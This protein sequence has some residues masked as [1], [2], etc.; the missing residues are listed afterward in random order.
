MWVLICGDGGP[1]RYGWL[2][3]SDDFDEKSVIL[4]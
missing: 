4:M 3:I 1:T 2:S